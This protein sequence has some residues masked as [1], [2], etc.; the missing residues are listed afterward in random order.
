MQLPAALLIAP[1]NHV[2]AG[3]SWAQDRLRP[4]GGAV[5]GIQ[6]DGFELRLQI[7][8]QGLFATDTADL[9]PDVTIA[10]ALASL[11][12][13]AF[14]SQKNAMGAVHLSG[15]AELADTVAFV[16]RHLEW[17]FEADLAGFVGDIAAHRMVSTLRSLAPIPRRTAEAV[18]GN[19][20]EYL[21][22]EQPLLVGK[23]AVG[24]VGN[25]VRRLRDDIARLEKRID[26]L[27]SWSSA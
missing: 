5:V 12:K 22:E 26:R 13:L 6:L 20:S 25:D 8:S 16:L 21:V 24:P 9:T 11:P 19:L 7:D 23:T 15:N 17:D 10:V 27:L 1:L 18:A 14:D 3:N 2:L 4:H